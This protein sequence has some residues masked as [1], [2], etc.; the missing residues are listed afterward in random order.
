MDSLMECLFAWKL[1]Y[2]K[3][4]PDG[5]VTQC[6]NFSCTEAILYHL[7]TVN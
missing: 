2:S 7:L 3:L 5:F 6:H 1:K 4:A